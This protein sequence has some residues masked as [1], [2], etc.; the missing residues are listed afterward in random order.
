M[1]YTLNVY[2]MSAPFFVP[3]S[4]ADQHI[5]LA[6][7]WSSS[8]SS[9]LP[10]TWYLIKQRTENLIFCPFFDIIFIENEKEIL[11]ERRL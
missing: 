9:W 1:K 5:K 2:A 4:V 11:Y 8:V 10:K 3:S 6:S 7:Q